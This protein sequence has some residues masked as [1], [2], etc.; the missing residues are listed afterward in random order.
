M[1]AV[2]MDWDLFNKYKGAVSPVTLL[3]VV[4]AVTVACWL[5]FHLRARFREDSGR[6]DDK[7]EMLTQFRELH[8]QGE[9]TEDEYRLIKGR[10]ARDAAS[11]MAVTP[12]GAR[13]SAVSAEQGVCQ[14][15][16]TE[17]TGETGKDDVDL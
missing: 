16:G 17:K 13:D 8:Q 2:Q 11:L 15:D 1:L 12:G 9:L 14:E 10:L 7:L 5:V 6:A 3:G 4:I